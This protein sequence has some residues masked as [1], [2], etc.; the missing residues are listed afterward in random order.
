MPHTKKILPYKKTQNGFNGVLLCC[1]TLRIQRFHCSS[2]GHCC[3]TGST[4]AWE[5]PYATGMAKEKKN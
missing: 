4:L 1:S 5:F 2:L 3:G